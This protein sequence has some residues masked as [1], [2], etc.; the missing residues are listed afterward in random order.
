MIL[1]DLFKELQNDSLLLPDFQRDFVWKR[2]QQKMLI[3]SI[4]NDIPVGSYLTSDCSNQFVTK[5]IGTSKYLP[6]G[7]GNKLLLDGQQRITT[8][9]NAFSDIYCMIANKLNEPCEDVYDKY[10]FNELKS[11]W[12]VSLDEP[13]FGL[14]FL[15]PKIFE[16]IKDNSTESFVDSI[17]YFK[18]LKSNG[19]KY[20]YGIEIDIIKLK[21]YCV[22]E[23]YIPLFLLNSKYHDDINDIISSIVINRTVDIQ[24]EFKDSEFEE[25]IREHKLNLTVKDLK[26]EIKKNPIY[27]FSLANNWNIGCQRFFGEILNVNQNFIHLKQISKVTEAFN[28]LNRGG[29]KLSNFDLFCSKFANL[30]VRKIVSDLISS[31]NVYVKKD[32]KSFKIEF[33]DLTLMENAD[34]DS[35]FAELLVHVFSLYHFYHKTGSRKP[36]I[37]VLKANYFLDQIPVDYFDK[38]KIELC[39]KTACDVCALSYVHFGFSGVNKIPNKLSLVPIVWSKIVLHV[40]FDNHDVTKIARAHYYTTIFCF[41]YDSHQNENCID[42]CIELILLLEKDMDTLNKYK[43]LCDEIFEKYLKFEVLSLQQDDYI[44]SS[45][46]KNLLNFIALVES[47]GL[48]DFSGNNDFINFNTLNEIHHIIPLKHAT[49]INQSTKEIRNDKT[50]RLNS[51][52]NKTIISQS[53]N[54]SIGSMQLNNY[55]HEFNN[56]LPRIKD[57]HLV[58]SSFQNLSINSA[59]MPYDSQNSDHQMLDFAFRQRYDL[60]NGRMSTYLTKWF[61]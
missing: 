48:K 12:F 60:L 39:V 30:G 41:R 52:L 21:K 17:K 16:K 33:S 6:A 23:R 47:T 59:I 55:F 1:S 40:D 5:Y 29:A 4:L 50:H 27:L 51:V 3:A 26:S 57:G 43:N 53:A 56:Y 34:I 2:P 46:E 18:D 25:F 22:K 28:Y 49:K 37:S 11:R 7:V 32:I 31:N 58:D 54:R 15:K 8:L 20:G 42:S 24:T 19:V 61:D 44:S 35:N 45:I 14:N 13:L 38:Q 9:F 10:V 36:E